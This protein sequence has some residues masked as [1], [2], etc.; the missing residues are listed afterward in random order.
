[1]DINY[2]EE[3]FGGPQMSVAILPKSEK[4]VLFQMDSRLHVDNTEKVL[5]L[6]VKGCK[7][8]YTLLKQTVQ[9]YSVE[10]AA[11]LGPN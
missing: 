10:A 3:G 9:S 7:D 5:S 1:M 11:A 4:I 2:L 8:V 6:A